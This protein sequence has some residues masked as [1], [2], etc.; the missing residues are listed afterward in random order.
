MTCYGGAVPDGTNTTAITGSWQD[1]GVAVQ[2]AAT[3]ITFNAPSYL[4]TIPGTISTFT[5]TNKRFSTSG[6]KSLYSF[7]FNCTTALTSAA[8]FYFD[9]HMALSPY[10]DNSGVV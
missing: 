10:L 4:A 1:T 3:G 8:V 9:F 2:S 7:Q 5:L 6:Y